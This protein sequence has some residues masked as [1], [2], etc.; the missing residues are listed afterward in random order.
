MAET[1]PP[2]PGTPGSILKSVR[3]V[4]GVVAGATTPVRFMR[5]SAAPQNRGGDAV[6]SATIYV[7]RIEHTAKGI[8]V[9]PWPGDAVL[10]ETVHYYDH[11]LGETIPLHFMASIFP[12]IKWTRKDD[13]G[14]P[15]FISADEKIIVPVAEWL[16]KSPEDLVAK[17]GPKE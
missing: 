13:D 4:D 16:S 17:Y 14:A 15:R 3:F 9:T 10:H 6:G 12:D 7:K 5:V 2:K 11:H 8:L 1:I